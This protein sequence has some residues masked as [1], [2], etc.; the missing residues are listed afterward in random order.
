MAAAG[1]EERRLRLAVAARIPW[2][3]H[4]ADATAVI[5]KG[6]EELMQQVSMPRFVG[7]KKHRVVRRWAC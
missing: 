5:L 7:V 6:K 4:I 2:C 1:I 3:W